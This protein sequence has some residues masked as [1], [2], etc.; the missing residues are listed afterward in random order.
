MRAAFLVLWSLL[1]LFKFLLAWRLP[2]FVD[3]A[4]YA[5]EARHLAWAYSDLPGLSAWLARLG[6]EAGGAR[7]LPLRLPFLLLGAAVPWLVVRVARHW[8]GS[9][10]GWAAGLLALL[11][12][13]S[14]LLG[15]MAMP[16]VP[17]V[18]AA[19]LCFD[20][21]ARLRER[22]SNSAFGELAFGLAMGAFSHYRFAAVVLAGAAG[23]LLD[24]RARA[25]LRQPRLWVAL[26]LGASAWWPLLHWNLD[27]A[28]AGL[29][30][31]L[32]ERNPWRFHADAISWLPL[33]LL[34]V[35]PA[36]FVLLL[37]T[38]LAAWRRRKLVEAP[39]GLLAGIAAVSV[40]GY[41][42]LGFF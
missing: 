8:P 11:M 28:A 39:W 19:L 33:Q 14:G 18:L 42:L 31:Q 40:G 15:V 1:L 37:V 16:D 25:L 24:P 41:F 9:E 6:L 17:L 29:R 22:P 30:F 26:V 23:L 2:V 21:I 38:A 32:V 7:T 13:L 36:L 10:G 4:F 20:A 12:P 27:H 5:W 34:L 3:E 35:T